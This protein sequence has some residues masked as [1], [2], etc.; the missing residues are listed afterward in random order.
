MRRLA[1]VLLV[2]AACAAHPGAEAPGS[3][4]FNPYW[5]QQFTSHDVFVGG[6]GDVAVMTG[7]ISRDRGTTW[8]P[9]DPQL[10]SP[11]RI[12]ITGTTILTYTAAQG[13]CA[14]TYRAAR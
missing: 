2:L 8:A 11:S 14:G 10:G 12:G 4:V 1:L 6:S 13:L 5:V 9:L 3:Y 7:R